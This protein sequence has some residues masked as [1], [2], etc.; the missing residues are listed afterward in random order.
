MCWAPDCSTAFNTLS[1]GFTP[2]TK[3]T[4]EMS[5]F[6]LAKKLLL[7]LIPKI[8]ALAFGSIFSRETVILKTLVN[9]VCIHFIV[10]FVSVSDELL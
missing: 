8:L 5:A 9:P 4:E 6:L 1:A 10:L 3:T 7:H 2:N